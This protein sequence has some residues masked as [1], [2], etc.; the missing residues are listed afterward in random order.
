[1]HPRVREDYEDKESAYQQAKLQLHRSEQQDPW[2]VGCMLGV[3]IVNGKYRGVV[4]LF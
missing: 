4:N 2:H 3:T 1:M